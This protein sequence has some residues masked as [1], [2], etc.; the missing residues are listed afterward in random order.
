MGLPSCKPIH[1]LDGHEK[2]PTAALDGTLRGAASLQRWCLPS[3]ELR[4]A[5]CFLRRPPA[6]ANTAGPGLARRRRAVR[7]DV[8]LVTCDGSLLPHHRNAAP[9]QEG[10]GLGQWL[11]VWPWCLALVPCLGAFSS[12]GLSRRDTCVV[13]FHPFVTVIVAATRGLVHDHR[14]PSPSSS[15]LTVVELRSSDL[16]SR[17]ITWRATETF[18]SSPTSPSHGCRTAPSV[19]PKPLC[20]PP[21][22][23]LLSGAAGALV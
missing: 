13:I 21:G 23:A 5:R 19:A 4:R 3:T 16:P 9:A 1:G 12:E 22:R 11:S 2:R 20:E 15:Q 10:G 8:E 6:M 18:A 17:R 14:C 7:C